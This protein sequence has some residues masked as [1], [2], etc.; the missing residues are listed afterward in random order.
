MELDSFVKSTAELEEC[1]SDV[2]T[3]AVPLIVLAVTSSY[4]LTITYKRVPLDITATSSF[5]EEWSE[6]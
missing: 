3:G 5:F 6:I 2:L 4:D 1:I